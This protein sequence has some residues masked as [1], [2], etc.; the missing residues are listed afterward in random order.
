MSIL[1]ICINILTAFL[2]LIAGGREIK[3][4]EQVYAKNVFSYFQPASFQFSIE[5]NDARPAYLQLLDAVQEENMGFAFTQTQ[6]MEEGYQLARVWFYAP[7][8]QINLAPIVMKG[9]IPDFS[10]PGEK[11]LS[12]DLEDKQAA[13][14][15]RNGQ[16][17]IY[18]DDSVIVEIHQIPL[19]VTAAVPEDSILYFSG[20]LSDF[21]KKKLISILETIPYQIHEP[22]NCDNSLKT[23]L[24]ELPNLRIFLILFTAAQLCLT[25]MRTS[26][27][28]KDIL[29]YQTLGKE[30]VTIAGRL[31]GKL[32]GFKFLATSLICSGFLLLSHL[33]TQIPVNPV[34]LE[35]FAFVLLFSLL[36]DAT[37]FLFVVWITSHSDSFNLHA[38]HPKTMRVIALAFL[39]IGICIV[40]FVPAVTST[41]SLLE[42]SDAFVR[43]FQSEKSRS[44]FYALQCAQAETFSTAETNLVTS[45]EK[46]DYIEYLDQAG[47]ILQDVS[48]SPYLEGET[49]YNLLL[50][51]DATVQRVNQNFVRQSGI[52][53]KDKN[54]KSIEEILNEN[55]HLI[56]VPENLKYKD[57]SGAENVQVFSYPSQPVWSYRPDTRTSFISF[58]NCILDIVPAQQ[59]PFNGSL[60]TC[61]IPV[62]SP[63]LTSIKNYEQSHGI[64]A[65]WMLTTPFITRKLG[66][67]RQLFFDMFLQA[68]LPIILLLVTASTLVF[69]WLQVSKKKISV[70]SIQG[71]TRWECYSHLLFILL[72]C[73]MATVLTIPLWRPQMAGVEGIT[74]IRSDE[75]IIGLVRIFPP[76][77][78]S[79][80]LLVSMV[81]ISWFEKK[82]ILPTIKGM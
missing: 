40:A 12:S 54:G 64:D 62:D 65:S 72:V 25:G 28:K 44:G 60:T 67:Y 17:L 9:V 74:H 66:F 32:Y 14:Y 76:F 30:P 7:E 3:E 24:S 15:I 34:T 4:Q 68:L 53:L 49:I 71:K 5:S 2:I 10:S 48:Q 8:D 19:D 59:I 73:L 63:A 58:E 56:L 75:A 47:A 57:L 23:I 36:V 26:L 51:Q 70:F 78:F 27:R 80:Q 52:V 45:Q 42:A 37:C 41:S 61:F 11:Y 77:V 46:A 69:F 6:N 22:Q 1:T 38:A 50:L 35:L 43:F 39:Q 82:K 18:T 20:N 13:G 31:F 16:S 21:S 81:W 79:L 55:E 33:L 29:V